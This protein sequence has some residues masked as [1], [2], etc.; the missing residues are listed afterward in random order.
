MG[1]L[2]MFMETL[3]FEK[4]DSKFPVKPLLANKYFISTYGPFY[5][6]YGEISQNKVINFSH[7][8]LSMKFMH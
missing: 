6:T 8:F 1:L 5:S 3:Y 7:I 2:C 4:N